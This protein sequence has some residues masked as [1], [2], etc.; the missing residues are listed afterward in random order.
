MPMLFT[1]ALASIQYSLVMARTVRLI[2]CI[3]WHLAEHTDRGSDIEGDAIT[4]IEPK[5]DISPFTTYG[6]CYVPR[7]MPTVERITYSS[8]LR[9]LSVVRPAGWLQGNRSYY[10]QTHTQNHPVVSRTR[11]TQIPPLCLK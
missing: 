2:I 11:N 4:T 9:L 6:Y 5:V 8:P 3:G 10:R 1:T 7:A